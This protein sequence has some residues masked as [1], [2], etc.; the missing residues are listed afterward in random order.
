M[1]IRHWGLNRES[2]PRCHTTFS[3]LKRTRN[4]AGRTR[5]LREHAEIYLHMATQLSKH[6]TAVKD[7][8]EWK[9]TAPTKTDKWRLS[10]Q[11]MSTTRFSTS[12]LWRFDEMTSVDT[13]RAQVSCPKAGLN[14]SPHRGWEIALFANNN[15]LAVTLRVSEASELCQQ[16]RTTIRFCTEFAC[17]VWQNPD[18]SNPFFCQRIHMDCKLSLYSWYTYRSYVLDTPV[19]LKMVRVN[20]RH[21]RKKYI[22]IKRLWTM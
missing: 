3:S 14:A 18:L 11:C 4:T 2:V 22:S 12:S 20:H 8:R 9:W 17:K 6:N 7:H 10:A 16:S 15:H 13:Y 5:K 19:W 1:K 21:P